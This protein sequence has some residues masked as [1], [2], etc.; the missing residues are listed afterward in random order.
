MPLV[1]NM[2]WLASIMAKMAKK[3]MPENITQ[4]QYKLQHFAT[5]FILIV[6]RS[7]NYF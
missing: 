1:R 5:G 6:C 3:M 7:Y 4:L 2:L